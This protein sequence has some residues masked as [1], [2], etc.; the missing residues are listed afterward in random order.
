MT[1][2]KLAHMAN[3]IAIFFDTQ[4]G[5]PAAGVAEH[6]ARYW[7]P[8]MR[9]QLTALVAAGGDGLRPAVI[10]AVARLAVPA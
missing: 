6:L 5:D 8:R 1:P 9:A 10:A 7:E 2:E 4:P 3:Q